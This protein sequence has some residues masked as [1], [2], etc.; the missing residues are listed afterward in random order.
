MIEAVM[1]NGYE[2]ETHYLHTDEDGT[3]IWE[4]KYKEFFTE[5]NYNKV[6]EQ[7]K[8][9]L[10]AVTHHYKF[11]DEKHTFYYEITGPR[12]HIL[13]TLAGEFMGV[14]PLGTMTLKDLL[15]TVSA[16]LLS[17]GQM[18]TM[19]GTKGEEGVDSLDKKV[20]V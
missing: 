6:E 4:L 18:T 15:V 2:I 7:T 8:K 12:I 19:I 20:V 10:E 1:P 3:E 11:D 17:S 13:S 5:E 9:S 14:S 16:A